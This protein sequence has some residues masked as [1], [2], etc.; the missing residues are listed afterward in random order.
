MIDKEELL[1]KYA[2]TEKN[3]T[4]QSFGGLRDRSIR[5]GI[6]KKT[7][8]SEEEFDCGSF[9]DVDLSF[10]NF[11]QVRMFESSFEDSY[12]ERVNFS[13][14]RFGQVLFY[15]VNLTGAIFNNAIL[16]ETGFSNADLSRVDFSG[17]KRFNEVRFDNVIFYETIM[18]DGS[19]R[20]DTPSK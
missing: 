12:M 1:E 15:N 7:N 9:I 16:G 17:V 3:F 11:R 13:N 18:P 19:I 2:G 20:T 14:A 4:G 8:F 10:A 6:Y 5:G